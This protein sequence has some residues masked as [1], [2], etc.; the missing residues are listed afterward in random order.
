MHPRDAQHRSHWERRQ[1][2]ISY[3]GRTSVTR[4]VTYQGTWLQSLEKPRGLHGDI[5]W[6]FLLGRCVVESHAFH[7]RTWEERSLTHLLHS[8]RLPGY[9]QLHSGFQTSWKKNQDFCTSLGITSGFPCGAS[10]KDLPAS[11]GNM[12]L[13]FDSLVGKI[14]W[15]RAWQPIP[16]FWPGESHG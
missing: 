9:A 15:R 16:V 4:D 1:F 6:G 10:G 13:R 7:K 5:Q 8:G 11:A 12:R 2:T 3:W 14:P